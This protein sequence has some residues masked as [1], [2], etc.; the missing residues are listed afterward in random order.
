MNLLNLSHFFNRDETCM[1][2][3]GLFFI[4]EGHECHFLLILNK[5]D[6]FEQKI[7]VIDPKDHCFPEYTGGLNKDKALEYFTQQFLKLNTLEKRNIYVKP[8][9]ALEQNHVG[10]IIKVVK[11]IIFNNAIE[12]HFE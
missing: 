10:Y 2:V 8:T 12:N 1:S 7:K 5:M 11:Q 4:F 3:I 6:L 9:C